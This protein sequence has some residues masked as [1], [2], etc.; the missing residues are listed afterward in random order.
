MLTELAAGGMAVIVGFQW[1]LVRLSE[2]RRGQEAIYL[3]GP[4]K[5]TANDL[6]PFIAYTSQPYMKPGKAWANDS[7]RKIL[8][9]WDAKHGKVDI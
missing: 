3:I 5:R 1:N 9:A 7:G 2:G 6:R 4:E 8:A